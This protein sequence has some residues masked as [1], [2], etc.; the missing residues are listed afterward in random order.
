MEHPSF[1]SYYYQS[2]ARALIMKCAKPI[3]KQ[4]A[5]FQKTP[6]DAP[7]KM[8]RIYPWLDEHTR[9][10]LTHPANQTSEYFV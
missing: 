2:D 6:S 1:K 10:V 3:N 4:H 5:A 7:S 8:Q 9:H